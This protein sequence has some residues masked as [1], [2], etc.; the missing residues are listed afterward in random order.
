MCLC[1]VLARCVGSLSVVVSVEG[2]CVRCLY[3]HVCVDAGQGFLQVDNYVQES[4]EE[5]VGGC[6]ALQSTP[7]EFYWSCQR[8]CLRVRVRAL[9]CER[10]EETAFHPQ[11]NT[12]VG[13]VLTGTE[14]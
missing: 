5:V 1:V 13:G 12:T 10:E 6:E 2:V 8:V 9:V 4:V 3:V 14:G 11:C 7:V